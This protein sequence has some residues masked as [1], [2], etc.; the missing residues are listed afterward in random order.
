MTFAAW[1]LFLVNTSMLLVNTGESRSKKPKYKPQDTATSNPKQGNQ[2]SPGCL[3]SHSESTSKRGPRKQNTS[4]KT[5]QRATQIKATKSTWVSDHIGANQQANEV[6]E[7]KI[8][9]A[10]HG[11]EQPKSRQP[12]SIWVSDHIGANRQANE[13]QETKIQAARHGNEQPK[14]RIKATKRHL[15][16]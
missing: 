4:R 5:R 8:Q 12:K 7:T 9:A 1:S 11:N 10:R 2:K 13:V 15:G 16:V 6:Q 3:G 14:S